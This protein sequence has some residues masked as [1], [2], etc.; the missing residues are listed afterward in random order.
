MTAKAIEKH[1]INQPR[2]PENC[3][4]SNNDLPVGLL[5]PLTEHFDLIDSSTNNLFGLL[6]FPLTQ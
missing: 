6:N 1:K 3:L 5:K 4:G 2:A